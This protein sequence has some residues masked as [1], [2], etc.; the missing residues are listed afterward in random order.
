MLIA[1]RRGNIFI[2]G[3]QVIGGGVEEIGRA[4]QLGGPSIIVGNIAERGCN[5]ETAYD[6]SR[7]TSGRLTIRWIARRTWGM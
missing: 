7:I 3:G 6:I 4:E 2:D 1:F 5:D